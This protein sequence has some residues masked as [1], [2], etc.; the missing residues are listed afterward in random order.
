MRY[1]LY[2]E[3]YN[4]V[5]RCNSFYYLQFFRHFSG[6]NQTALTVQ[7]MLALQLVQALRDSNFVLT[8][9]ACRVKINQM[10]RLYNAPLKT[11]YQKKRTMP[12]IMDM[13]GKKLWKNAVVFGGKNFE[14]SD[15][16]VCDGVVADINSD[17]SDDGAEVFDFGGRFV[18]IPGL[19]DVH[20][21]FR[22][23]GFSYKETMKTGSMSAAAGG[24]TA[25][26]TMPNL[27]PCPDCAES[28]KVQSDIIKRDSVIRVYPYGA[29]TRGEKSEEVA[30]LE[31]L[32]EGVVGFSD[33]G[34]GVRTA[35]LMEQAM[36][37]AK[38]LSKPIVAHCEDETLIAKGGC[39]H[40]G[41]LAARLGLTGISSASEYK[42]VE[43][44]IELVRRTGCRYHVCH[45]STRQTVDIIRNAKK[46]GLDVSCETA[47]HYLLLNDMMLKDEG[48]FKMNPPVRS[49]EDRLALIE[50]LKDGTV[51]IIATDHAPHTVEEKSRGLA[52]SLMG[53]V[54]LETAF[55]VLY[56]GLVKK[57][58]IS[59]EKL[60][61]L[62]SI[63]PA[64]RFGINCGIKKGKKADFAVFDLNA[65]YR[66]D[67]S[68]FFTMG[69]ATPFEGDE[70]FGRCVM[71]VCGGR[72][73]Y[74]ALGM[75][76]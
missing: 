54:G 32:A 66:I 15:I 13:I 28:L 75:F 55:P 45:V 12:V 6:Q 30:E 61:C 23:P 74:E 8:F 20:V 42:Q 39:V 67:P 24:Y 35:A 3:K 49:E 25:V 69:R 18:I 58:I 76:V 59:L 29:I 53:V 62:M 14:T 60:V 46:E 11:E 70:V 48:R 38:A 43:R 40:D 36:L 1:V 16:L 68:G 4:A 33:D 10:R 17:I 31:E 26:C 47:P 71:T 9:N 65:R 41:E 52:G 64:R 44:D 2:F 21:H 37:R 7:I 73:V 19:V 56:T 27:S 50:G 57:G 72:V 63:S 5:Y 51:D 22:E 34:K